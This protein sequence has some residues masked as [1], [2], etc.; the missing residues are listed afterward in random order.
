MIY[1][2]RVNTV[3]HHICKQLEFSHNAPFS[4]RRHCKYLP[5]VW[6]C[7]KILSLV[8]EWLHFRAKFKP[9]L[10]L[11]RMLPSLLRDK[12]YTTM[13]LRACILQLLRVY[14]VTILQSGQLSVGLIAQLVEHCTGI[15]K[16]MSSNPAQT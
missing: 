6:I 15:A 1:Q 11:V 13:T 9:F 5:T 12:T 3:F 4:E 16:V 14:S 10:A 7:D 2:T 8:F